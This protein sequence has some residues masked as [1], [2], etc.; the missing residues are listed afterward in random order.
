MANYSKIKIIDFLNRSDRAVSSDEKGRVFEDLVVYLF[1]KYRGMRVAERNV[2]DNT[3]S[4][5]L[6]VLFWNNRT[7]SPFD[8]LDPILITECKNEAVPLSSAKCREFVAKLRSRGA[9][10]GL[11]ISSS[12]IAG[13]EN[14][15]RYA[16]SVIMDALTADRIKVIVID[17]DDILSINTTDDLFNLV[18]KKFLNLTIRRTLE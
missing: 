12:G 5:E 10:N 6:D 18:S 9:N 4:Q 2:L 8:F 13:Q 3:G 17:R 16:N 11:L 15:Y 14:G 1:E 7:H